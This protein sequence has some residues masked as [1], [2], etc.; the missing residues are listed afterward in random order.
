MVFTD[1]HLAG[2]KSQPSPLFL[3]ILG[4]LHPW[5]LSGW[6]IL[7]GWILVFKRGFEQTT[8]HCCLSDLII[9]K[10]K[11]LEYLIGETI[12]YWQMGAFWQ[13][14]KLIE[15]RREEGRGWGWEIGVGLAWVEGD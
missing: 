8:G 5:V 15:R 14:L 1:F 9:T 4:K 2:F 11:A 12:D 3:R 7:L 6:G 10:K 13:Q